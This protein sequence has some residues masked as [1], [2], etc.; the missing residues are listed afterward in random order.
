MS[1]ESLESADALPELPSNRFSD[2]ELSWLAFNRR[3]LDLARDD[4]RVPLL[5]RTRFLSIFFSNLDEFF[6]VRVAGLKRRINADIALR[7]SSGYLPRELYDII[8]RQTREVTA[9]AYALFDNV[10]RPELAASGIHI[11]TWAE[12][13]DAEREFIDSH[14][15]ARI[16]PVLDPVAVDQSHPMPYVS[17]LSV[18]LAV[19]LRNPRTGRKRFGRVKVPNNLPRFVP[20]GHDRFI[21]IE[22]IMTQQLGKGIYRGMQIESS[23]AFRVTRNE[24]LEVEEDDAENLLTA[25]EKEL[26]GRR[27]DRPPVRLEVEDHM[28]T[29]MLERLL[30]ELGMQESEVIRLP[31]MLDLSALSQFADLERESLKYPSFLPKTHPELAIVE[32]SESADIFAALRSRDVLLQHPYDAFATSVQRFIEQAAEDPDVLTIRQTLYRTAEDSSPIIDALIK[33]ARRGKSVMVVVELKARFDEETN[34]NWATKLKAAGCHVIYG[35]VGLKTHCKLAMVVREEGENLRTYC[36]VGTGNY[37]HQTARIYEDMGLLTANPFIARD[38]E[39]VFNHIATESEE[40]YKRMLVA[41]EGVRKGLLRAIQN[42]IDNHAKGLPSGIRIK[43]NSIIDETLTD[44]LYRASQAGVK[45]DM[46][47]RGICSVRPGIPGLSENIRV[48][49]ILGRF[50]EHSRAYWFANAGNPRVAIGSS[51]LMH[52]NLDRRVE[53]L[54]GIN[55]PRHIAQIEH[56]FDIAF[57]EGTASWWLSGDTWT[58]RTAVDG[59]PLLD[60][61]EHLIAQVGQRR[62]VR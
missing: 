23:A 22:L 54:V 36:H 6:R 50:L 43:V 30:D 21:P 12:L 29:A 8:F 35:L 4:L 44:A 31:S 11:L 16:R 38:V 51:D 19:T 13:T 33:A 1:V 58:Q 24:D 62:A 28:D 7:S 46:W 37:N 48:R 26:Q 9:E 18:S 45:V 49:S 20:L 3:V 40:T 2:R 15:G 57:D 52:R 34:I 42:E 27:T 17:G 32:R 47:V 5:E 10:I 60:I 25:L 53:V 14:F 41:P 55:H 61:Q 39:N 59:K 56:L